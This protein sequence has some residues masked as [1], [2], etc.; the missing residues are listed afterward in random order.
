MSPRKTA[1]ELLEDAFK[2]RLPPR[3]TRFTDGTWAVFYSSLEMETS[4]SE[5]S[6]HHADG[7]GKR[8]VHF[9][10][11][12]CQFSGSA[13]DLR[14][15]QHTWPR[16]TH[17]DTDNKFCQRVGREAEQAGVGVLLAPS[18]RRPGGTTSSVFQKVCLSNPVLSKE[19]RIMLGNPSNPFS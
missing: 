5:V 16:L 14:P 17:T 9:S 15:K 11:L 13:K 2:L 3:G 1:Q 4:A 18:V 8:R 7:L 19:V 10:V 12:E 6:H